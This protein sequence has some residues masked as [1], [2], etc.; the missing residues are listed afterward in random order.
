MFGYGNLLTKLI[1][2]TVVFNGFTYLE[3]KILL[4]NNV[5]DKMVRNM[6]CVRY[7]V[8]HDTVQPWNPWWCNGVSNSGRDSPLASPE[9]QYIEANVEQRT[10]LFKNII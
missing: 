4:R 1:R 2:L 3:K 6:Y 7:K 10:T 8:R 5:R 9:T